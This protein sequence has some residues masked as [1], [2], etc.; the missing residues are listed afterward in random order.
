MMKKT[1]ALL[2]LLLLL[3]FGA[4]ALASADWEE[5]SNEDGIV[6][7]SRDVPDSPIVAFKGEGVVDAPIAK[8][9]RVLQDTSRKKEW[10]ART[11]EVR[12]V[13]RVSDLEYVEYIRSEAPGPIKDRDFVYNAKVEL[14]R[15]KKTLIVR[16]KSVKEPL[17]PEN[18]DVAVRGELL[19]SCYVLTSI[20][21]GKKTRV[22]VEIQADPKGMI[23]KWVVNLVQKSW[24]R[25]TLQGIRDQAA[26][27]DVKEIEKVKE[28]FAGKD[29]AKDSGGTA[30]KSP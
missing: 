30:K 12:E 23:P 11:L 9:A 4:R 16:I 21:D 26:K 7:W 25:K 29:A 8:V 22:S 13:R 27:A 3:G 10:I 1:L 17:A 6:C 14:D 24:P 28:F 15:E 19:D 20:E 18:E 2:S 5:I